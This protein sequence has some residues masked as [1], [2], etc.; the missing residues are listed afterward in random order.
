MYGA[1]SEQGGIQHSQSKAKGQ[2]LWRELPQKTGKK[3]EGEG[4]MGGEGRRGEKGGGGG[5]GAH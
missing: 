5:G 1:A 3:G 2:R 4:R